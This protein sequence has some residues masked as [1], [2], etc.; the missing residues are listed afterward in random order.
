MYAIVL[1]MAALP[2]QC[3]GGSYNGQP[4]GYYLNGN[5]YGNGNGYR[6]AYANGNGYG[7]GNGNGNGVTYRPRPLGGRY[8]LYPDG[9]VEIELKPIVLERREPHVMPE[10]YGDDGP[11]LAP[12]GGSREVFFRRRDRDHELEFRFRDRRK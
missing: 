1:L 4:R 12:R 5:G 8:A 11:R 9:R 2:G 3:Q 7:N 6:N 10:P